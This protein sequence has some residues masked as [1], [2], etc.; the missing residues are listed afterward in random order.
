MDDIT[1]I[2]Q[3]EKYV[4]GEMNKEEYAQFE[5]LRTKHPEID[6][7]ISEYSF[8]L[9]ELEK[10][11]NKKNYINKL[12]IISSS[13]TTKGFVNNKN[14]NGRIIN[15]WRKHK[16]TIAIAASI[17]VIVSISCATLISVFSP[18]KQDNLKPLVEKLKEQDVKYKNLENKIGELDNTAVQ[19]PKIESK[20]RATGFMIDANNNILI[21]NAHVVKEAAHKLVVENN[22]GDQYDAEAIFIDEN[23]DIAMLQ[24]TDPAFE[25]LTPVPYTIKKNGVDLGERFFMMGFPKQEIV[26]SEGYV[27]AK[28]GHEMDSTCYQLSSAALEGNSGSPI[29]NEQGEVIGV[30]ASKENNEN[31]IV[32]AIK[33]SQIIHSINEMKKIKEN[34][35]IQLPNKTNFN[36]TSRTNQI[37]RIQDYIFMIKGN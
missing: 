36:K 21:T 34:N 27:S 33:S 12:K 13:I 18:I 29:I 35:L 32:Y 22:K 5:E 14:N 3:S 6:Q 20:F 2:E 7:L 8:F 16:K 15:L 37:K 11:S 9:K 4:R 23:N 24:I 31:S 25:H 19:K 10:Y 28:N 30:I 17:A 26:Y 1:L